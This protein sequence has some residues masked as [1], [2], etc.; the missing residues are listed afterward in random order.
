MKRFGVT[1]I[2]DR[3]IGYKDFY[4]NVYRLNYGYVEGITAGDGEAQDAYII[5][6]KDEPLEIFKGE[7]MAVVVRKNDIEDKWVVG[8]RRM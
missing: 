6:D 7:V 2:V 3:P 8:K 4:G 5:Y 1:V